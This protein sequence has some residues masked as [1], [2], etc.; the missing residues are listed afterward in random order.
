MTDWCPECE[1]HPRTHDGKYMDAVTLREIIHLF[2]FNHDTEVDPSLRG[3]GGVEM[4]VPLTTVTRP[5]AEAV[6]WEDIDLLR[7]IFPKGG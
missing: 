3:Q 4:S 2:G 5:D 1:E 7:C 6:L